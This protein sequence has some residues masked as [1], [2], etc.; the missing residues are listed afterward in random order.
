MC[1]EQPQPLAPALRPPPHAQQKG[2][3]AALNATGMN[4]KDGKGE[5]DISSTTSPRQQLG[6]VEGS[7]ATQMTAAARK[8][9]A[10]IEA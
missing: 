8:R 9:T 4:M 1:T 3:V 5:A 6:D 10:S 7:A 2:Q